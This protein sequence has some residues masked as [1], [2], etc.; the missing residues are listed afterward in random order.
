[1]SS[2]EEVKARID[3]VDL[4]SRYVP[5]K[6]AGRTY[7]AN[8]PF[9]EERTPS[10]VVFPEGQN[11]RCFGACSTGGDAF[12]FLMRQEALD[13]R[14][15]LE[16]LAIEAGVDLAQSQDQQS[17]RQRQGLYEANQ[18]AATYYNEILNHHPSADIAREYLRQRQVDGETAEQFQLGF[19]L[20]TWDSLRNFLLEK[21]F[22]IDDQL[23]AGLLKHNETRNSTYDAFRGRLMI[24][25]RD[26]QGR[27]TGFGGRVLGDGQPKYLNTSDTQL[28]HKSHVV[29]G[30]DLAYKA[31]RDME[32]VVIVEGY[33]DVIAAHQHGF[34]NVVACMGTSLTADQLKQLQRYTS[35]FVLALDADS[36]GQQATVRGLNQARQAL[37]RVTKPK[38][39]PGGRVRMEE[40]LDAALNI[41]AMP[42]GRDPDDV[43]RNSPA[44][45]EMLVEQAKPLVD[46]YFHVVSTQYD[47]RSARGKGAA[48]S[49]LAPLI[50]EL[51][52]EIEQQ[53]YVQELSRLLQIDESTIANRVAAAGKTLRVQA[54]QDA[55]GADGS[56][57]VG[58]NKGGN[59]RGSDNRGRQAVKRP[60]VHPKIGSLGKTPPPD[61]AFLE[62]PPTMGSFQALDEHVP[63]EIG[64]DVSSMG[65]D[66]NAFA[67]DNPPSD[68]RMV[69]KNVAPKAVPPVGR[70][71][72]EEYLL[73][74][75]LREPNLLIW[76][77]G[78]TNE[79]EMKPP[80]PDDL[81]LTENQ[82]IFRK[83]KQYIS[84]DE[85]WDVEIFQETIS[86]QLHSRLAILMVH[87]AQ[88]PTPESLP[89]LRNDTLKV[90]IRMRIERI[91]AEYNQLR[92]LEDE[93]QRS[94]DLAT[95]KSYGI[96]KNKQSRHLCHLQQVQLR[97]SSTMSAQ[98]PTQS[99][100][101]GGTISVNLTD[102]R[103]ASAG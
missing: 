36:A 13:F 64:D 101:Y 83:L 58:N 29:Y 73:A 88:L 96:T 65:F 103:R 82:E 89:E 8:C 84:G 95:A 18:A 91:K 71:G 70:A 98:V 60:Q 39:T 26:K 72:N 28:F 94:N 85:P 1:M 34:N 61:S 43:I 54:R 55:N 25:I 79:H 80:Q 24:P 2:I 86:E 23:A 52:D 63:P 3:I 10:F 100:V 22:S 76:L 33:M 12:S 7:K 46:F 35:N 51:S 15:A 92:F 87:G 59:N 81:K 47:L 30:M 97:I 5:L 4:V 38:L 14:E 19:A 17:G 41:V 68:A 75:L 69:V 56:T 44:D 9:H 62:G 16:M 93:A 32:R 102:K 37:A 40:R 21:G 50:A 90:L 11:W 27:V 45:W 66:D 31:I 42:D 78:A 20:D 57:T 77:A 99:A 48:V 74:N 67:L 49:E 6:K 53:H